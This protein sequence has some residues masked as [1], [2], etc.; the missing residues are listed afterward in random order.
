[1]LNHN[2]FRYIGGGGV[3]FKITFLWHLF[4]LFCRQNGVKKKINNFIS[5][6]QKLKCLKC[7]TFTGV[8]ESTLTK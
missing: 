3:N 4:S 8:L 2:G 5:F 1:M 6:D 7:C